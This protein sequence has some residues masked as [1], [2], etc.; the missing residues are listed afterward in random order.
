MRSSTLG[1]RLHVE[2][3]LEHPRRV[4]GRVVEGG[5]VVV[6]VLDLRPLH[7]PVAEPD[8][9]VLDQPRGAGDQVGVAD[10]PRRRPGQGDVDPVAGEPRSRARRRRAASARASSSASSSLRALL[11]AAADLAAFLRRQ[12]GDPAQDRRQLGFAAEVADPQLLQLGAVAGGLDRGRGLVPDLLDPLKHRARASGMAGDD[13]RSAGDRRRG[14]DVERL[15]AAGAQRDRRLDLALGQH[16]GRQALAL[17]AEAERRRRPSRASRPA[18][19]WATSATRG[20]GVSPS[21]ARSGGRAKIEP[22]LA[23]TAF[24][25]NGSAQSGPEHDRAV[26]QRVGG[27]DDRRRRCRDRRRRAGRRSGACACSAQ[28]SG[29]TAIA[30]VPE[31]SDGDRGQQLRLDLLA[32]ESGAGGGQHEARL[33]TGRQ[34]GLEQVLALGREQ[35]LALAVLALAQLADQLQLLVLG[36]GDHRLGSAR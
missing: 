9:H 1:V 26:E 13:I 3:V 18:P 10:R 34:P 30:R 33:G 4:P 25:E 8:H 31:P 27:A 16:R 19:P 6:V 22:M 21:S 32:A 17:G 12:L 7:H 36:A 24:G 35:P 2:G 23:R 14:G 29:Q 15:G 5:E 20:A 28:R 11:A